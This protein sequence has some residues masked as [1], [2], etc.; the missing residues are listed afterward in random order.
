VSE[1]KIHIIGM[2]DDGLDGVTALAKQL[3]EQAELLIGP[4]ATLA[5]IPALKGERLVVG[6]N[7]DEVIQ[8]LDQPAIAT[9]LHRLIED[10]FAPVSK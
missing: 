7:L 8:R 4:E 10:K 9:Y 1:N 2:G 5:K 3:A 6:N